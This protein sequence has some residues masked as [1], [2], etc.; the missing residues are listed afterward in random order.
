V[1]DETSITLSQQQLEKQLNIYLSNCG[2]TYKEIKHATKISYNPNDVNRARNINNMDF[3][4]NG[5]TE[6][7]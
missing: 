3:N 2:K 7:E 6:Q 4:A 1:G 5:T